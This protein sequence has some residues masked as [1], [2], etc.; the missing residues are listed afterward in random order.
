MLT[1]SLVLA[2]T[3]AGTAWASPAHFSF[4]RQSD[5]GDFIK[6]ET[7]FA[8]QGLLNN[9]GADGTLVK[10][11][12]AG[13]VVASPSKQNPDYFY[14]WT[15]D[16]ALTLL[17]VIEQFIAGDDS[18][19]ALIHSYIDAQAKLQT[20]SNP[21]GQLSDGSGL[22][23]PKFNVDLSAFTGAWGRPQRDGPALRA[24][25]LIAYGNALIAKGKDSVAKQ[26]LWPIVANDLA[27]VGQYWNQTGFDLWEEVQ[28]SSFF[29]TAVQ[30]KSLIEGA[31]FAKALGE[32]CAGC[33]VAPQILCFLQDY[34]NGKN[35]VSNIANNGRSGIDSNSVLTSIHTFDPEAACDD[36]TFQPCSARA[37]SNLK[38]YV[39]AFRSIYGV[40]KD[41]PVGKAAA[42][43]RYPEDNYQ[44][45]N[46][47]YLTTLAVAEQLYDALYQW[48]KQ[49]AIE[50]N[51]LSLPFFKDLSS[52]VTAGSYAKGS[53]GYT[54]LTGAVKTYADEFIAVI[55]EYT[56]EKGNLAEQFGRD[57]GKPVSASDLTWSY[58]SFL[59]AASR[60]AGQVPAS[61]GASGANKV[62]G[63]CSGQTVTGSYAAPSAVA[64]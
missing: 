40:N 8:K 5:I 48:D 9:I 24:S 10:G 41:R 35:I 32:T 64:W 21:S 53:G 58:A 52:N 57:S 15:R 43:G 33:A 54:S 26:H 18:L 30:H 17:E 39:D 63:S 37:L 20:V 60:R 49:G 59:T 22:A 36:T 16:S 14:T 62:P 19:E 42:T 23:E 47:W 27:Y 50:V 38:V 51:E 61:W 56:P 1:N 2:G 44:G 34:W 12:A 55:K 7:T 46:P 29:T 25:A 28:G 13:V 4:K 45:G 3:L 11:A 31:A 6:S